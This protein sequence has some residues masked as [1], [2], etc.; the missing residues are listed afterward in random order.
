MNNLKV[1]PITSGGPRPISAMVPR[2]QIDTTPFSEEE[3]DEIIVRFN[4]LR[5]DPQVIAAEF[6]ERGKRVGYRRI[7]DV[8]RYGFWRGVGKRRADMA[9]RAKVAA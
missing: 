7:Y 2:R 8:L 3:R 9:E 4:C 5:Q 6:A 1:S